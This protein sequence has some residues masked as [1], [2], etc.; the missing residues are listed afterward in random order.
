VLANLFLPTEVSQG[1]QLWGTDSS[2]IPASAGPLDNKSITLAIT[3]PHTIVMKLHGHNLSILHGEL[4]GIISSLVLS[5][6]Q[7][8]SSVIY[9]DHLNSTRLINDSQTSA[10]IN[11][12]LQHM[13]GCSYYKWILHLLGSQQ[14]AIYN[15]CDDRF[16]GTLR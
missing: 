2:I 16:V 3:G 14:V 4:V 6:S 11:A 8:N 15:I 10:N 9:T 1:T 7:N 12:R 5:D 13:N